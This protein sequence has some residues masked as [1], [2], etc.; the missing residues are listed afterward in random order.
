MFFIIN[1]SV[2]IDRLLIGL[3]EDLSE[4]NEGKKLI[5]KFFLICIRSD[6][7]VKMLLLI[8]L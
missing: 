4:F 7:E 5:C 6:I 1:I 3:I 2:V 8:K